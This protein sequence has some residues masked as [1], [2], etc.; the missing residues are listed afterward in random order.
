M[1]TATATN[2]IPL[3]VARRVAAKLIA[4]LTPYCERIEVAGSIRRGKPEVG[5]IELVAI[6]RTEERVIGGQL[7]LFGKTQQGEVERVS[8]L[9]QALERMIEARH[10]TREGPKSQRAWGP[11]MKK[12]WLQ[13]SPLMGLAKVDLFITRPECW[14]PIMVIRTGPADFSR[15]LVMHIA[16]HTPYRQQDGVLVHEATGQVIPVPTEEA[17]FEYAGVLFIPPERRTVQEL[18]RAIARWVHPRPAR[19]PAR[20]VRIPGGIVY[21]TD[22]DVRRQIRARLEQRAGLSGV[23][24]ETPDEG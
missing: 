15:D 1:T 3:A 21:T 23:S 14:G 11:R 17:Y 10:I 5:D 8:L 6:S 9:D 4:H 12:F 2:K 20:P 13:L 18:K 7:G 24:F 22:A 19:E 16:A